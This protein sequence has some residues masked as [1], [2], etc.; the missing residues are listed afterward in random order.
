MRKVLNKLKMSCLATLMALNLPSLSAQNNDGDIRLS[1]NEC[2]QMAVEKNINVQTARIDREKSGYKV[3]ETRAALL[4][5]ININGNFQDYLELPVTLLPGEIVGRPG[6]TIAGEIGTQYTT[7]ASIGINQ[8]LYNQTALT[9][10]QLSKKLETLSDLSVEKAS[11]ELATEVSKLYFLS[12]TTARQ[13]ALVEENIARVKHLSG[14]VKILVDNG[15]GKQ[16]DY[17]RV[18]V[19]LENLYTQL[20]NTEATLEQQINL[21]KYTLDIPLEKTIILTDT[22]EMPLLLQ[23][24]ELVS[25]FSNHIDIQ[26]LESQK[27]VNQLNQ[28]M[29]TDG[30][31]PSLAFTGQYG[32]QGYREN[33]KNY[34]RSTPE[35]KWYSSSYIGISLSIPVFDG[36]EKRSKS[37][38]AR[39]DYQ[40]TA[41]KLDDTKERFNVNYQNALNNYHNHKSNVQRQKQN[42]ALA[43]KVYGETALKYREGLATMSDLL[44]DEMGLNN[45][46]AGYLSALY[47]FKEA[48]LKIMS[49]NG[50]IRQLIR[51]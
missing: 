1:L 21:I 47:N 39:L 18:S 9:A 16:V 13:K 46:Q 43:E 25:D 24:P 19:N 10:L 2:V 50:E 38:Q 4:P 37:R 26:M 7:T 48:E 30:Y 23:T 14:I 5:K 28:K 32:Y 44:Q 36:L 42:I 6:T 20:S 3:S 40:K 34:F 35:N 27:E 17:K 31:L 12:L 15:M 8:V 22:A 41:T 49:L 29:I 45:A 11:E 51:N 33:F